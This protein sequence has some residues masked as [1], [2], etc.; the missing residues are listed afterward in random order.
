MDSL[1]T[2]FT[3]LNQ[4]KNNTLSSPSPLAGILPQVSS[5][6]GL[7]ERSAS[8]EARKEVEARGLSTRRCAPG[9]HTAELAGQHRAAAPRSLF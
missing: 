6:K 4:Q 8:T 5:P 1:L 7:S 3:V 9:L 2:H